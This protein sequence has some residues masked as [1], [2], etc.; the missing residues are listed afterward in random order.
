[1]DSKAVKYKTKGTCSKEISF[2][3]IEGKVRNLKFE[4]GC[5]G[6]LKGISILAEGMEATKVMEA[7]E[8]VTCGKKDT[9]CPDQLAKAIKKHLEK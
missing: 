8:G 9:S 2:T 3:I 7:L 1:M 5:D 6:N 4:N